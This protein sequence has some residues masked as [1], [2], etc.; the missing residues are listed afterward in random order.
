MNKHLQ[1]RPQ[2]ALDIAQLVTTKTMIVLE[3]DVGLE[4][5]YKL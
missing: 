3:Q 1:I 5:V 2:N 4:P